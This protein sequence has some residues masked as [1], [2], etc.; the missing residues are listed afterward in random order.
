MR[1]LPSPYECIRFI[2]L[3]YIM[4]PFAAEH[5][6]DILKNKVDFDLSTYGFYISY[7]D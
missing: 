4:I 1:S 5:V 7:H 3:Y 6:T 2:S